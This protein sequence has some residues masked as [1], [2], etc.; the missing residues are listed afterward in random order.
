[1]QQ[2]LDIYQQ[3]QDWK[4]AIY[5]AQQI[6]ELTSQPMQAIIAQYYCEQA[7]WFRRQQ[8]TLAALQAI[9]QAL[10]IDPSCVRASLLEGQIALDNQQ[11]TQ[12]ISAFKRVEYQNPDYLTE[13][14]EPLQIIYQLL[15]KEDE[16]RHYLSHLVER[17]GGVTPMLMLANLIKQ[18]AGEKPAADFII[19]KMYAHP[20]IRGL[21]NL[22]DLALAKPESITYN[23]LLLLK[24]M[25]THLLKN[26]PS[27]KCTHCGFTARK[28]H[29]QCPSCKQWNSL[30][31]IQEIADGQL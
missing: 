6:R 18:Q 21:D 25:T 11:L 17:Y 10:I 3:E 24:E 1:L 7:D 28:L 15:E 4:Q 31:A 19:Q 2:L 13:V 26:K 16:F 8:Q 27:Y 20:S 22:L 5:V 29:W 9:Q 30:K 12:A 14:I 23:H